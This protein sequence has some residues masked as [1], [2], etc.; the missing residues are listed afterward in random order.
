MNSLQV[1]PNWNLALQINLYESET[2]LQNI[3][4]DFLSY[5][6]ILTPKSILGPGY[7][8]KKR[9]EKLVVK[10]QSWPENNSYKSVT[11]DF[12]TLI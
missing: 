6:A 7:L 3:K 9:T 12:K 11:R 10:R 2:A 4:D 5:R 1:I 8:R